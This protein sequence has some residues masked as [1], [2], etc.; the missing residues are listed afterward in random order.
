MFLAGVSWARPPLCRAEAPLALGS[1]V[2]PPS[3]VPNQPFP[4]KA[5]TVLV[6]TLSLRPQLGGAVASGACFQ[7]FEGNAAHVD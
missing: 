2:G 5:P 4:P 7:G 3:P 6:R 1:P